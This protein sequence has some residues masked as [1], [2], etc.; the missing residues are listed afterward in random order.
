MGSPA[1]PPPTTSTRFLAGPSVLGW[2][3]AGA[4]LAFWAALLGLGLEFREPAAAPAAAGTTVQRR[5]GAGRR[6]R[7]GDGSTPSR[8][9]GVTVCMLR[10][11]VRAAALCSWRGQGPPTTPKLRRACK[12]IRR[13][14]DCDQ[15]SMIHR[16]PAL[17]AGVGAEPMPAGRRR[18][19][20]P[21]PPQTRV[22]AT[23]HN[24]RR[25]RGHKHSLQQAKAL[26]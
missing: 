4:E 20:H 10:M 18:Q 12:Q 1:Q 17:L 15:S 2:T 3:A 16:G 14:G 22:C 9:A 11:N 24:H 5:A 21:A 19:R 25:Y 7:Q 8:D 6:Y 13:N 26:Q 23:L